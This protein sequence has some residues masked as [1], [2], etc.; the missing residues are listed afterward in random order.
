MKI[1][2]VAQDAGAEQRF[3]RGVIPHKSPS[4]QTI[5]ICDCEPLR[6]LSEFHG[7]PFSTRVE[8]GG[9]ARTDASRDKDQGCQDG[10]VA[11]KHVH[12][13]CIND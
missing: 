11:D 10:R 8:T 2:E 13:R 6:T 1:G 7:E 3:V 9:G 5:D 4:N 12:R